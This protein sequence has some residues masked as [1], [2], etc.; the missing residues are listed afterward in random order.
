MKTMTN[1]E[2]IAYIIAA[3]PTLDYSIGEV[4]AVRGDN[5]IPRRRFRRSY[6]RPDGAQTTRLDGVCA[7]YVAHNDMFGGYEALETLPDTRP[8]GQHKF[9]LRGEK[10]EDGNDEWATEIILGRHTIVAMIIT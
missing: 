7:C 8:Y 10:I 4:L 3:A 5:I 9:L 6:N 2:A 1:K